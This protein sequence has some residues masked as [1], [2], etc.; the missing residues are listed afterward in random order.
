MMARVDKDSEYLF[1]QMVSYAEF[2]PLVPPIMAK[3]WSTPRKAAGGFLHPDD[4]NT[5]IV[6]PLLR[7]DLDENDMAIYHKITEKLGFDPNCQDDDSYMQIM[8]YNQFTYFELRPMAPRIAK[9]V[10]K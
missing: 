1:H 5:D 3:G 2:P 7:P 6:A 4:D 10:L 8:N 9:K